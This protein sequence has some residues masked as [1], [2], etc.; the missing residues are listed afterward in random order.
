[1]CP[2]LCDPMDFSAPGF[3][4]LR[5]LPEFAQTHVHWIVEAIS[6]SHPLLLSSFA[7]NLSQHQ[8]LFQGVDSSHQVAKVLELQLWHQSFQWIFRVDFLWDWLVWS[9]CNPKD[10]QESSLAQFESISFSVLSLFME[11]GMAN[12]CSILAMK[13]PWTWKIWKGSPSQSQLASPSNWGKPSY[14][15]ISIINISV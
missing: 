4:V 13:I 2:T 10:S 8:D 6:P 5:Y 15:D 1:M 7:F 14:R 3:P 9:P 12:Y 11:E